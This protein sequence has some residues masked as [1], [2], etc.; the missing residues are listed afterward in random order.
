M[1]TKPKKKIRKQIRRK[2]S[3][4]PKQKTSH[5]MM[6]TKRDLLDGDSEDMRGYQLGMTLDEW[7]DYKLEYGI[8]D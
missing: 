4:V 3:I 8:R 6:S 2:K 1:R 7:T 5:N